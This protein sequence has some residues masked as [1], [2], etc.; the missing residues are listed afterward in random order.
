MSDKEGFLAR[1]SRRKRR[2]SGEQPK[3]LENSV[4]G[5]ACKTSAIPPHSPQTSVDP[6]SLPPIETIGADS[7]VRAFLAPGVPTDLSRAALRRAWSADPA[8]RD[9]VGLSENSWDFT[10]LG[11]VPGFGS[12]SAED[13]RRLL[14]EAERKADPKDPSAAPECAKNQGSSERGGED[15]VGSDQP[16][17]D[18]G[19]A[20]EAGTSRDIAMQ[21]SPDAGAGHAAL[22][23]RRHG[24]ALPD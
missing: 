8:I 13:A 12:L 3:A 20:A 23:K 21:Q 1:W 24:G 14:A 7:D 9:F 22:S 18:G 6:V 17:N 19:A 4:S 16:R 10:A 15:A 11:G 5:S 2:G